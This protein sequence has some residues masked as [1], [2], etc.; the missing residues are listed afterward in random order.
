[1][2]LVKESKDT[3]VQHIMSQTNDFLR[4]LTDKVAQQ[5]DSVAMD[6]DFEPMPDQEE[7]IT[8]RDNSDFYGI[9]H[10]IV[11]PVTR[12]PAMMQGGEL[13]EY[14]LKGLQ[15]MVSLY[16]NKLN[17]ILADEMGL[18]KT[19][20]TIALLSYLYE[21]KKQHG[22]FLIIVPLSTMT[23][24]SYELEKWAPA[25]RKVVMKGT[26]WDR[27]NIA[28]VIR[29]GEFDVVLT[30]FEYII[31]EK[32]VLSKVKWIHMIIDEGHRMK[33]AGSKLVTTLTQYYTS[34]YRLILTGTPLQNNLPELWALLNF[35][36]PKIFASSKT[37]EDWF[38]SP[39]AGGG[40]K[41]ELNEEESLLIIR[42]L[43]Q[44]LRPFLLRRLKKDVASDL[45]DKVEHVIR[46]GMSALQKRLYNQ[47]SK[48]G[49]LPMVADPK[50]KHGGKSLNN[51]LMHLRKICNHPYAF[52]EIEA[53]LNP[54]GGANVNTYRASGKFEL[55][56]RILPKLFRTGHRVLMFFQMK[57]EMNILEDYLRWRGWLWLRLDGNSKG[58]LREEALANFNAENSPYNLFILTTRAGGLGLN[59]QAA[60]TVIIFDSDWNPH[61]DLQAQDRAHRIGQKK[62]VLV[63]RLITSGTVEEE[64]QDRAHFK[65]DMDGKVIQAGKFDDKSSAADR[66]NVLKAVMERAK[67]GAHAIDVEGDTGDEEL[68]DILQRSEE[69]LDVFRQV[70]LE[71]IQ[72]DIRDW[73]EY[74]GPPKPKYLH[75]RLMQDD[76][77]PE[78]YRTEH[79]PKD[80][81]EKIKEEVGRGHRQRKEIVYDDNLTEKQFMDAMEKLE[82]EAENERAQRKRKRKSGAATED[83]QE[84]LRKRQREAFEGSQVSSVAGDDDRDRATS[85]G[86][87]SESAAPL[88]E[89]A[90]D[91]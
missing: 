24:W 11:E 76:E 16:N 75:T 83:P 25:L 60:D 38:N 86:P 74:G 48:Y 50:R 73:A 26:K 22:P 34:R 57:E 62:Q 82:E 8:T 41:L 28:S 46:C 31:L 66:E 17:G 33:N 13:K 91:M 71:R 32:S 87:G 19:I 30:T 37:F 56:D 18:G 15:W 39:F 63:L 70:D 79:K 54:R 68:N 84:V 88:S 53:H 89:S 7:N 69:E 72:Q 12:Q 40:E 43:H 78:L 81:I 27:K 36:C 14:Q 45:P 58:E 65:L 42:R 23:N 10:R 80:E 29:S 6:D 52:P 59:L 20:Q 4:K 64:I 2:R 47:I 77:V 1:M 51:P 90:G 55:L 44:V 61:Q 49:F 3:R 5:Q 67:A 35:I 9:A 21:V 85:E